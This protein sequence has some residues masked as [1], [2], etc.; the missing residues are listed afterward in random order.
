MLQHRLGV[1]GGKKPFLITTT[2]SHHISR[3]RC[4]LYNLISDS[5]RAEFIHLLKNYKL[6][7]YC[8]YKTI[9]K[10]TISSYDILLVPTPNLPVAINTTAA[11]VQC[12]TKRHEITT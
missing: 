7:K 6:L 4:P 2:S 8:M 11:T 1:H 10:Q 5:E 3:T 12:K 9:D